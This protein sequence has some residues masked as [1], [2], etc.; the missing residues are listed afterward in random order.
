M[1]K[2]ILAGIGASGALATV[3]Q[4]APHVLPADP[5]VFWAEYAA[6]GVGAT[7]TFYLANDE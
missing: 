3:A 2:D 7:L 5:L 1:K 4:F 6:V